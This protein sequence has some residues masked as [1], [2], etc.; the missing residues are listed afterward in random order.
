MN[1]QRGGLSRDRFRDIV[2][3]ENSSVR[4]VPASLLSRSG[5]GKEIGIS[6][7]SDPI[8]GRYEIYIA[9]GCR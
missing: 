5:P 1:I 8:L 9:D 4:R 3:A 7:C 2:A 6:I